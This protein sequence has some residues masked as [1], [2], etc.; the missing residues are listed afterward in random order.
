MVELAK[1]IGLP[2]TGNLEEDKLL[3]AKELKRLTD[4]LKIKTL[5]EQGIE[6]KDFDMLA[7]DVLKEPVLDFNPRQNVTK[8]EIIE[9]LEKA[10]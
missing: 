10:F 6:K 2:T 5:S 7:E 9:I 1:V 3:L 8:K 4:E